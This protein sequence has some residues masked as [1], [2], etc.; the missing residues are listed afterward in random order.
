MNAQATARNSTWDGIRVVYS[1]DADPRT[2]AFA[3][4]QKPHCAIDGIR[5]V[6]RSRTSD[7]ER[8]VRPPSLFRNASERM[9][10]MLQVPLK[11]RGLWH[12][13]EG[14]RLLPA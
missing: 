13:I 3:R 6:R 10:P 12:A 5:L 9:L 11:E 2:P 8:K 7:L 14:I 1:R 4:S